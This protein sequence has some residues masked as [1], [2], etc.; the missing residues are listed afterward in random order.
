MPLDVARGL[1]ACPHCSAELVL[2]VRTAVCAMGHSYDVAK[3]GYLNLLGTAPPANADT[4]AMV[5]A[6]HR[7]LGSG[8]YGRVADAVK[9]AID[10]SGVSVG[11]EGPV[12]ADV[13]AGTGWY[14]GQVLD[15]APDARGIA[16]DVSPAAARRAARAHPRAASIVADTWRS[17]PLREG[18]VD[19]LLCIFAPRNGAEFRRVVRPGGVVVV[20]HPNPQHLH[21][22]R[23]RYGLL[24]VDPRKQDRLASLLDGFE[25]RTTDVRYDVEATAT[26]ISDLIAMG[27]NAFHR[28]PHDI[29][30]GVIQVDVS[31][32]T[33]R[34]PKQR[35][36]SPGT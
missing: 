22:V 23:A 7:F 21:D 17:L 20:V 33:A 30:S 32:V 12:I 27:P 19:V 6:R 9:V 2:S 15:S 3:Q 24:D 36:K 10:D 29:G 28:D 4:A 26:Q 8:V 5:A 11:R 18:T 25:R 13:G 31:I 34:A 35:P 16:L 1:L 14:L